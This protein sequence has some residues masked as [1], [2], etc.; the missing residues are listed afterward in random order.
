MHTHTAGLCIYIMFGLYG[1]QC[2]L[3]ST[4]SVLSVDVREGVFYICGWCV[5]WRVYFT[6]SHILPFIASSLRFSG[7]LFNIFVK[8]E[9]GVYMYDFAVRS[10]VL[11]SAS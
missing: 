4:R 1:P 3:L 10:S 7:T 9:N 8:K 5:E 11:F 6:P 2:A